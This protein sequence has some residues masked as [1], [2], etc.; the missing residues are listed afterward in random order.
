MGYRLQSVAS[1]AC[2]ATRHSLCYDPVRNEIITGG[3]TVAGGSGVLETYSFNGSSFTLQKQSAASIY[4]ADSLYYTPSAIFSL[5]PVNNMLCAFVYNASGNLVPSGTIA[6]TMTDADT[7]YKV[8]CDASYIYSVNYL[9]SKLT[10][11]SYTSG[12]FTDLGNVTIQ[13]PMNVIGDG[14]HIFTASS[15]ASFTTWYA[16]TFNGLS[17]TASGSIAFNDGYTKELIYNGS[18]IVSLSSTTLRYF[19]Y[20]TGVFTN[21]STYTLPNAVYNDLAWDG[22]YY[23]ISRSSGLEMFSFDGANF[24]RVSQMSGLTIGTSNNMLMHANGYLYL[25]QSSTLYAMNY[26]LTAEFNVSTNIGMA[27]LTVDFNSW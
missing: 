5:A 25:F 27:P 1:K 2:L 20:E 22:T 13:S 4:L 23:Y 19:T 15:N 11:Y 18:G 21:I 3:V 7:Y 6:T 24:T 14:T 26:N 9:G 10:A 16:H 12:N 8:Y 17:F